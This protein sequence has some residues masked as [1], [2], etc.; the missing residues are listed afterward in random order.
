MIQYSICD[1]HFGILKS[2]LNLGISVGILQ[3]FSDKLF[4]LNL[5]RRQFPMFANKKKDLFR[6]ELM[7]L[8]EV[9]IIV[10][11]NMKPFR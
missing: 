2:E 5:T 7:F 11:V 10:R 3:V 9:S 6:I 1:M 4:F 8:Q